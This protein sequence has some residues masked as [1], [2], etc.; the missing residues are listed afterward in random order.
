MKAEEV[1]WKNKYEQLKQLF[2]DMEFDIRHAGFE[3]ADRRACEVAKTVYVSFAYDVCDSEE[4]AIELYGAGK[5][6]TYE[7]V[8]KGVD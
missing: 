6:D 1:I 7:L 3:K 5:Y 4:T 8:K 2:K